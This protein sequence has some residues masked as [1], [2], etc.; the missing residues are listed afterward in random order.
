[1]VAEQLRQVNAAPQVIL[2]EPVGRNTA[3]AVAIAALAALEIADASSEPLLLV[4]PADHVLPDVQA[5]EV[6]VGHAVTAAEQGKLVTFGVVPTRPETGYGYI[7]ANATALPVAAVLE[8]VEKP[9]AR[10][11]AEYLDSGR[12]F[13]EQRH[14]PV[15]CSTLPGRTGVLCPGHAGG[16]S[17]GDGGCRA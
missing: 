11:A 15:F 7:K 3:P 17:Q 14:V 5:F 13:L 1:M 8:F 6:A 12:V 10:R 16:L 4:L 9:D 2:L